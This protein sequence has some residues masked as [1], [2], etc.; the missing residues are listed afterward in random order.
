MY[1]ISIVILVFKSFILATRVQFMLPIKV[2][3]PSELEFKKHLEILTY[4]LHN[5]ILEIENSCIL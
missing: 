1:A 3:N 2:K 4:E 5:F